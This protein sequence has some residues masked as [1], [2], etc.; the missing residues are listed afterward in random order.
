MRFT[1][2]DNNGSEGDSCISH[3]LETGRVEDK[4]VPQAFA[5]DESLSERREL[6]APPERVQDNASLRLNEDRRC[7]RGDL[8]RLE[9]EDSGSRE[10]LCDGG[11]GGEDAGDVVIFFVAGAV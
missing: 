5:G 7:E 9:E 2:G 1:I 10:R 4:P 11:W 3:N 6:V 8:R